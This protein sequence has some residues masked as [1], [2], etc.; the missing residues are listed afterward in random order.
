MLENSICVDA[1][2]TGTH[3][4]DGLFTLISGAISN[5]Y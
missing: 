2:E 5:Y 4:K 3:T 1:Y